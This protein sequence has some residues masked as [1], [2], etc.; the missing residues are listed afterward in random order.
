M[1]QSVSVVFVANVRQEEQQYITNQ[2]ERRKPSKILQDGACNAKTNDDAHFCHVFNV[3]QRVN[4]M[5]DH[6][7]AS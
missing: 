4:E 7:M 6:D 1:L 5:T 3:N 2:P